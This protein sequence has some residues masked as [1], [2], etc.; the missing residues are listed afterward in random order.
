M[1]EVIVTDKAPAAIGPYSQ[2]VRYG[3]LLF[4]SGQI[5]LDAETGEVVGSDVQ[6]QGGQVLA[7]VK[8][9]LEAA[10]MT[11]E[12]V[13][14]CTVFLKSLEDFATFNG[15]YST[16]FGEA[17]PARECVEVSRLPRD[18]LVEVSAICGA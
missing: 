12:N 8:A 6:T 10:G 14:K 18:V 13:L 3:N 17:L 9:I 5:P 11:V 2:A 15:V 1:R 4:I 16:Y 7:N